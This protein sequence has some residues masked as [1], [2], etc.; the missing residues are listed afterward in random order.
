MSR[1]NRIRERLEEAFSPAAVSVRDDSHL[2]VGHPGARS[3]MGHFHVDIVAERF[4][5]VTP[6]ERHR[7]I[8]SAL[9][10]MMRTD[11]HALTLSARA[12]DS[13]PDTQSEH[14]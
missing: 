1:V 9:D 2:H 7:L 8:Y 3:G 5:G 4:R 10:D 13:K 6:L 14:Y 11:I 12:P